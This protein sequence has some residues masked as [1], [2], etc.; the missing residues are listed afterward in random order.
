[1]RRNNPALVQCSQA[2]PRKN[3]ALL[4]C[5]QALPRN[6]PSLSG[7][8]QALA[9]NNPALPQCSQAL[10]GNNPALAQCSLVSPQVTFAAPFPERQGGSSA[11]ACWVQLPEGRSCNHHFAEHDSAAPPCTTATQSF[12]LSGRM[13]TPVHAHAARSASVTRM[14]AARIAGNRPP[15]KPTTIAITS[16]VT[17]SCG[18][19]LNANTTWVK[20]CP[21]VESEMPLNS[22]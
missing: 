22:R 12:R 14:R 4:Q 3:L 7:C 11:H 13:E 17:T 16:P 20:F 9:W 21:S 18:V 10:P 2:L 6:N 8:S 1:M 5:S 15:M 19:T